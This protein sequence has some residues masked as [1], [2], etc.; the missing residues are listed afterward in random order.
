M[1]Q[2]VP[3]RVRQGEPPCVAAAAACEWAEGIHIDR[4]RMPASHSGHCGDD[5]IA[6]ELKRRRN[7]VQ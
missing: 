4:G 2:E 5:A 7:T 6:I 3:M 1:L